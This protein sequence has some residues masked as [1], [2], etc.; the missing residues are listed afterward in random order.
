[1][2]VDGTQLRA[3]FSGSPG[4][5]LMAKEEEENAIKASYLEREGE[6]ERETDDAVKTKN[7]SRF[8]GYSG[9]RRIIET[10]VE[11][12]SGRCIRLRPCGRGK[13]ANYLSA[14]TL[15][16]HTHIQLVFAIS[17]FF[18]HPNTELSLAA[19][20]GTSVSRLADTGTSI[21][22]LFSAFRGLT[23]NSRW[24]IVLF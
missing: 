1:M 19:L 21:S 4:P 22:H 16:T 8:R 15:N 12:I 5:G 20:T 11:C 3:S 17:E 10:V 7:K 18:A 6:G 13:H 23:R 9:S 14:A 24:S 2:D